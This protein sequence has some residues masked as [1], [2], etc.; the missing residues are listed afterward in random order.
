MVIKRSGMKW[1]VP[2][3]RK[4]DASRRLGVT[5]D[6]LDRG[7][8]TE[9]VYDYDPSKAMRMIVRKSEAKGREEPP[10]TYLWVKGFVHFCVYGPENAAEGVLYALLFPITLTVHVIGLIVLS[11]RDLFVAGKNNTYYVDS[12]VGYDGDGFFDEVSTRRREDFQFMTGTGKY[13][14]ENW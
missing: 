4:C 3:E 7:M 2:N 8:G 1:Q 12:G 11:V 13:A 14:P 5:M 10:E 9:F 6:R